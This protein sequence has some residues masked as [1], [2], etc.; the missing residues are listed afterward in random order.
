MNM[1]QIFMPLIL[2]S[3]RKQGLARH[4]HWRPFSADQD[5]LAAAQL[6]TLQLH[7]TTHLMLIMALLGTIDTCM[8]GLLVTSKYDVV[9]PSQD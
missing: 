3:R 1:Y 5:P 7:M 4:V 6:A 9:A 2:N 8:L